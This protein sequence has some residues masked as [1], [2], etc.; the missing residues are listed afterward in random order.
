MIKTT[1]LL[2]LT[3]L[4][5]IQKYLQNL[6]NDSIIINDDTNAG[7]K[8]NINKAN[9]NITNA[10]IEIQRLYGMQEGTNRK[11]Y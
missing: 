9:D 8:A 5:H 1:G 3:D 6:D 11:V 4:A 2:M 10:I 7:I